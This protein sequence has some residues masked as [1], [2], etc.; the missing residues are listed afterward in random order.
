MFESGPKKILHHGAVTG[1]IG[2]GKR[3]ASRS[4]RPSNTPKQVCM[5]AKPVTDIVE[6]DGMGE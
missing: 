6:T 5:M 3:V 4:R 2:M 1:S